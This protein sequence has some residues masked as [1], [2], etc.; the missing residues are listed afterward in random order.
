MLLA[1]LVISLIAFA[2]SQ[3]DELSFDGNKYFL[4]FFICLAL[5]HFFV[6]PYTAYRS[7][8]REREDETWVL[9]SLTGLGPRRIL[10]GKLG[11]FLVQAALYASAATPFMLF[12]YF[13]NG[14]DLP[15]ILVTVSLGAA[16]T[17]FLTALAVS[18]A[19]LA[20]AKLLRGI[21]HLGV[22][23]LLLAATGVGLTVAVALTEEGPALL[24]ERGVQVV[25]GAAAWAM[26]SFGVLL[27]E[28]AAAR[29]ALATESYAFGP[30]VVFLLQAL[31]GAAIGY[32]LWEAEGQKAGVA[33]VLGIGYSFTVV[34]GGAFLVTD[35]DGQSKRQRAATKFFSLLR[36]GAL[37][38]FRLVMAVLVLGLGYWLTLFYL[39]PGRSSSDVE[40]L[41][42]LVAGAVY[43]ALYLSAAVV[44][45]R[46]PFLRP[47]GVAAASRLMFAVLVFVGSSFPPLVA[48]LW[49]ARARAVRPNLLNPIVGMLNFAESGQYHAGWIPAADTYLEL[50]VAVAAL[51]VLL[52]EAVLSRRD[53]L[54][55]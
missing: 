21:V 55:P 13:L 27:F 52:A 4:A 33:A 29:L 11:S 18:A 46:L 44:A 41:H 6:I 30:R 26:L 31:V 53:R 43:V 1:C 48:V 9:L 35:V 10:R 45:G 2:A 7:L 28:G 25:I 47:L 15:T 12:S 36:P 38:G 20:E 16:Y 23:A 34:L 32:W 54:S 40:P 24:R 37:R 42:T 5:V 3:Q 8:A 14:I 39:S 51:T 49:G 50:L 17:V 22:L 19:T